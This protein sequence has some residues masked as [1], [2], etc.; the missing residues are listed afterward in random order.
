MNTEQEYK[1]ANI[2]ID[3]VRYYLLWLKV[4]LLKILSLGLY[5][6]WA[7][8]ILN[9]YLLLNT[10]LND[11][12]FT[13]EP[14]AKSVFKAR[15]IFFSI[16]LVALLFMQILPALTGVIELLILLSLPGFYLLEKRYELNAISLANTAV[17]S[18]LSLR[19]FYKTIA[20]PVIIFTVSAG[21]IFNNEIIDS[22]FLASIET[23]ESAAVYAEGSYL[24]L[25]EQEALA[26]DHADHADEH[27]A[28]VEP[29]NENISQEEKDYLDGHEKSHNH[30]SIALSRLQKYQVAN[31]GNQFI[32]YV[33]VFIFLC[34]LWPWV[35]YKMLEYRVRNT[36]FLGSE[37]KMK[38]GVLSLY[39]LYLAVFILI[40]VML[41][42]IG[43][44]LSIFLTGSEGTS[45][46]FWSNLLANFLW[47]LPLALFVIMFAFNLLFVWRKQWLLSSLVNT[48]VKTKNDSLS[49]ATFV[50][51]V[52]NSLVVFCTLGLALPWF[53]VRTRR[54]FINH[55]KIGA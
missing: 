28:N 36:N 43:L 48:H 24:A 50:L 12:G 21:I 9:E 3:P 47:L 26:S 11:Q 34:V 49:L 5:A 42:F 33:L 32:Q 40:V 27:L 2:S 13:Q 19:E 52:T 29:W 31:Q 51:A 22:Q 8:Q 16:L 1:Q 6:P 41:A 25:A 37:W 39:R 4:T 55:F 20:L 54:Y 14:N 35:D 46:E 44:M 18:K 17:Q 15:L 7:N 30:G 45:P 23:K 38:F 53:H 10:R